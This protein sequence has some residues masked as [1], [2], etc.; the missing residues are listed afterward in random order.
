MKHLWGFD[1]LDEL[2]SAV[3]IARNEGKTPVLVGADLHIGACHQVCTWEDLLDIIIFCEK[4]EIILVLVGDIIDIVNCPEDELLLWWR[5]RQQWLIRKLKKFFILG[6][7]ACLHPI[8]GYFLKLGRTLFYHSHTL[9]DSPEKI[10]SEEARTGGKG[11][12]S[13]T[14]Y[15]FYK[16]GIRGGKKP[17]KYKEPNGEMQVE[18]VNLLDE[19]DCDASVHGHNHSWCSMTIVKNGK[20]YREE[21]CPRGFKLY[22]DLPVWEN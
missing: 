2:L 21:N 18:I 3:T 20:K 11:R 8:Y 22:T 10:A 5:T 13:S 16:N 4:H 7:H 17:S 14:W 1:N 12:L 9:K 15:R 19:H 6:N